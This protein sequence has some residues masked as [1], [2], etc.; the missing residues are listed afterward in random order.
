VAPAFGQRFVLFKGTATPAVGAN[1][2]STYF[3]GT[4]LASITALR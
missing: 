2:V 3:T 4:T 1:L